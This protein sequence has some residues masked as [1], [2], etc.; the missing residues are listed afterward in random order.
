MRMK[1]NKFRALKQNQ[2]SVNEYLAK[3][4]QLAR[5]APNDVAN[6]EEKSAALWKESAKT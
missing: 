6:E 4:N 3:F 5:Y 2:M 1:K